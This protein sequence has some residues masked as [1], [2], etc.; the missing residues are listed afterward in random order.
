[1]KPIFELSALKAKCLNEITFYVDSSIYGKKFKPSIQ[2]IKQL[3]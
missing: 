3:E 1:M 2:E